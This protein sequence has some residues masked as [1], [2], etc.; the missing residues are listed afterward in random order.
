MNK[1]QTGWKACMKG[2]GRFV[3]PY[4]GRL[5][6]AVL[7]TVLATAIYSLNPTIEGLGNDTA[8]I[9]RLQNTKGDQRG[10]CAF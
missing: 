10:S 9:G 4:K 5:F 1:Q 7:T 8:C 2:M 3:S 6:V